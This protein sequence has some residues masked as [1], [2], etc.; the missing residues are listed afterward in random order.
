MQLPAE[1]RGLSLRFVEGVSSGKLARRL[2]TTYAPNE[3]D[4]YYC[5]MTLSL[6]GTEQAKGYQLVL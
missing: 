1:S 5:S 4:F 6:A 2:C 3:R